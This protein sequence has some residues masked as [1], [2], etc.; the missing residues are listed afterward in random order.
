MN[1]TPSTTGSSPN[2]PKPIRSILAHSIMLRFL[3]SPFSSLLLLCVAALPLHAQSYNYSDALTKAIIFYDANRCGGDV[4]TNNA[5]NWRTGCHVQ[6]QS[7]TGGVDMTGGFHDAGD[8]L[9]MGLNQGFSASLLGWTLYEYRGTMDATGNTTKMLSTLKIFTDYFLKCHP[10]SG[11]FWY[12]IGLDSDHDTW[13]PPEN[14][15]GVRT[16]P[17]DG[18]AYWVDSTHAGSDICG[19]TAAALALMSLNYQSTDSV[20]AARCLQAAKEIYTLGKNVRGVGRSNQD[21]TFYTSSGY[22]DHLAWGAIWLNVATGTSSYLTE[23]QSF[24]SSNTKPTSDPLGWDSVLSAANLKIYQLTGTA[25]YKTAVQGSLNAFKTTTKTPGGLVFY[26]ADDPL[27]YTISESFIAYHYT[28]LTGDTQYKTLAT[29]QLNYVLGTNPRNSSY[30]IGF[31]NNWPIHVQHAA[32]NG[33]VD[34]TM[35]ST[36]AWNNPPKH[37]L[38][39][40]MVGGPSSTDTYQDNVAN[41][42]QSEPAIDYNAGL[43]ALLTTYIAQNSTSFTITASAGTNGSITPSG[44]VSVTQGANQTFTIHPNSGYVVSA[45]T[46]DGSSVGAVTSYTFSNVQAAHTI[47]ASFAPAAT[48]TITASAGANGSISPSGS[49]VVTQGATQSFTFTPNSGYA[50]SDVLVDGS[51]VGAVSMYGFVNVQANHTISVSFAVSNS[52]T[53]TVATGFYNQSIATQTGQFTATFDAS[54]SISPINACVALSQGTVTAFTGMATIARFNPTGDI[55]ARNGG[56]YAAA[57]TIPYSANTTY[58][59]RMVI[60]V[61]THT[62]SIYVTPAGGSELTVGTNYAFRTEQAGVTQLDHWNADVS[63]SPG[64][65]MTVSNVTITGTLPQVAAPT[66]SPAG[67]SY[68]S[69]QSVTIS[70]T[71]SG[72]SIRYTT[73]GSTPTSTTGTLYS[74]PVTVSATTTLKA[75]AYESGMTDSAVSSATYTITQPQVAAPTFSPGGGSYS[76]AQTVTV[77]TTTSGASIRYTTDGSTPTSTT[78]TLYSGPVTISATSTLKAIAYASGMTDSAVTSATYTIGVTD[79]NIAPSGT[80]YGWKANTSATANTNKTAQAGLNDNNL[81]ADVDINSAGDAVNAWEGAGVTWTTAKTLSSAKFINGTVTS[82]GDGFLTANCKLQFSTDGSTWVDSG[83]TISPAYPNSASASGQTYTFSG[84]AVSG[85]LGARVVG[86][87][88]TTDTSYHWIVKEVQV[89][90][91]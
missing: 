82:G 64:G 46:V 51:S 57:A 15:T 48:F 74:G 88:R 29:A 67:G 36:S 87:V 91:H 55:D 41:Y 80:G 49:V 60:N 8:Y 73:D 44:A 78:G 53:I 62:Y 26:T 32:A 56:A 40:G 6:D 12:E 9:K 81:T 45:V 86:Q 17:N 34:N 71:T 1:R 21:G 11:I 70:T 37:L 10:N 77:S 28:K 22:Y 2:A 13:R 61:S 54:P 84:T 43:V 24:L 83:W 23:A 42:Q 63:A 65:S 3:R 31:G 68:T 58:H 50:V 79:T 35:S 85:K 27:V 89:I 30:V 39:G 38:V 59:F 90:G 18:H 4:A 66:F 52:T 33:Y 19:E 14:D 72:A 5:F 20:Y 75:I 69:A 25:S 16:C 7:L 76:T 47:S